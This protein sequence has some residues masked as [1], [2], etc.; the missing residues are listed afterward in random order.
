MLRQDPAAVYGAMEF[1][2]RDSY[3]HAVER[4]AREG[5][6]T[7]LEVAATAIELARAASAGDAPGDPATHV[8][9]H[10]IDKG[11]PELERAVGVEDSI[12]GALRRIGSRYPLPLYLGSIAAITGLTTAGLAASAHGTG[13]GREMMALVVVLSLLATS[14]FAVTVVNWLATLLVTPRPLPRMDF[15]AGIAAKARTLVVVPTML[16]SLRNVEDLVEA[17]EVRFL[18]NRDAHLHFGLLT[19]FRRCARGI[20]R[21]GR[22]AAATGRGAASRS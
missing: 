11:L 1:A 5:H 21:H 18:A 14:Q 2:T 6:L 8:G 15:T 13:A 7:E 10:L 20:A 4:I 12:G 22:A 3:R 16:T 9:Y 17:L 19:D